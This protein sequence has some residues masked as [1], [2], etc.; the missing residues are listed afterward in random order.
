VPEN[1]LKPIDIYNAF[2]NFNQ[3]ILR[4]FY[5]G[6]RTQTAIVTLKIISFKV[7][8]KILRDNE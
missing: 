5:G 3:S 8:I 6:V 1:R 7:T 4:V 2:I